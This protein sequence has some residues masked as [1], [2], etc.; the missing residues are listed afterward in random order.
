MPAICIGLLMKRKWTYLILA[1]LC[2]LFFSSCG[3]NGAQATL[4]RYFEALSEQDFVLAGKLL[5]D[6]TAY[7]SAIKMQQEAGTYLETA[8][9]RAFLELIYSGISW[10][11]PNVEEREDAASAQ[12]RISS[13][14]AKEII[15]LQ[16]EKLDA[17]MNTEAYQAMS[18][19]EQYVAL[20]ETSPLLFEE[21]GGVQ[22]V[23][24]VLTVELRK[25]NGE[26]RILPEKTLFDALAGE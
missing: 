19:G 21:C 22:K 10:E 3:K 15:R 1:A 4:E 17:F 9:N 16:Q 20:C 25:E 2:L 26:W 7:A 5:G 18:A 14:P 13:Y 12:V 24:T 23:E 6:E 11:I 8:N